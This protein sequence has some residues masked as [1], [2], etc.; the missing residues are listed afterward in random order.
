MEFYLETN[1]LA[2]DEIINNSAIYPK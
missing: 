2:P 1:T